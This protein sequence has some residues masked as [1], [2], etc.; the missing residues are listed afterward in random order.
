[1]RRVRSTW[2]NPDLADMLLSD[3]GRYGFETY[4]TKTNEK[5]EKEIMKKWTRRGILLV[6]LI[7]LGLGTVTAVYAEETDRSEAT[8]NV[9]ERK[10]WHK[11]TNGKYYYVLREGSRARGWLTVKGKN[12]YLNA[13]GYRVTGWKKIKKQYYYFNSKGV[14]QTEWVT[15]KNKKYYCDPDN[16]GARTVGWKKIGKYKYYFDE[17]GVMFTGLLKEKK[18]YYYFKNNGRMATGWQTVEGKRSYFDKKTGARAKGWKEIRGYYYYFNKNGSILKN[19]FTKDGYYVDAEGKRLKKSTLKEFL[20]IA[21]QPVGTTMYVWG[22]GWDVTDSGAGIDARTIGVNSQWKKFFDQ[23]TSAYNYQYTRYQTR[24]GLDCSGFV[25]WTI[26]NAFNTES[27]NSGYVYLAQQMTRIF[28][29][30]GWGSYT[31]AGAVTDYRAGDIMSTSDGHVYIVM[32]SCSDGS[33]VFVHSSPSGVQIN[34]TCTKS[35]NNNSQA[36]K[37]AE[38][39]MK[40]YYPKWYKKFPK[41]S[42][43]SSYLLRYSQMRWYLE[44]NSM[45]SDP[46]GYA[47]KDAAAILKDLFGK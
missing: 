6:L 41:C 25:G 29:S 27:G 44:G 15:Y 18:Q 26:Y 7:L 8:E 40:K 37:L 23:Q 14:L 19:S 28:S 46:D 47:Q 1:M 32:G 45:M 33:V 12:Y 2:Q 35:G 17:K 3:L 36:I 9:R 5:V 38:K 11:D 24:N 13:K 10:G 30:K 22:G 21:L 39:Y 43:G 4:N 20:Q 34:G 31:A 16:N 42:R